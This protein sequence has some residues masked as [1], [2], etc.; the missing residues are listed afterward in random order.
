MNPIR[1][2]QLIKAAKAISGW[3]Y[4]DLPW[5]S[6]TEAAIACLKRQMLLEQFDGA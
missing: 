2:K 4:K 5:F 1:Q 3:A 6:E